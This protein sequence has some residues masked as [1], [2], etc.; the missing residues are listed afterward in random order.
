M[1]VA[2]NSVDIAETLVVAKKDSYNQGSS[3]ILHKN[4]EEL[5]NAL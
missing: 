5:I 3:H 1:A 4:G 2:A